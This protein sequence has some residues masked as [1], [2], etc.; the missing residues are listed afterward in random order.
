[1]QP[2]KDKKYKNASDSMW[3][4]NNYELSVWSCVSIFILVA[5]PA[6]TTQLEHEV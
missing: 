3:F 2:W 5:F 4:I 6:K 1:M